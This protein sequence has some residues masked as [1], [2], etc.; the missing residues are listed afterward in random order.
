MKNLK[1]ILIILLFFGNNIYSQEKELNTSEVLIEKANYLFANCNYEEAI[2]FYKKID[3]LTA[4]TVSL[5][6][7]AIAI[8]MAAL[9]Y[10]KDSVF[11]YLSS[12][13]NASCNLSGYYF[14]DFRLDPYKKYPEWDV[15]FNRF[16]ECRYAH[17][18]KIFADY[19]MM[20]YLDQKFRD[21]NNCK[22]SKFSK[23]EKD[24]L[25]L[26]QREIDSLNATFIYDY[27]INNKGEIP[28]YQTD[29][30]ANTGFIMVL[31]HSPLYVLKAYKREI[32]R[33]YKNGQILGNDYA[34]FQDKLLVN[35]GKK[36]LYGTQYKYNRTT[37]RM[38]R[39]PIKRERNLN[40]RIKKFEVQN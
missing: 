11:Y 21:L 15:I 16:K 4:D 6:K 29:F 40:K 20:L 22:F 2:E 9:N 32:N 26:L 34:L 18:N 27:L 7:S 39:V 19:C 12:S 5:Y 31:L 24:S 13:I 10:H 1:I 30:C 28:P 17:K 14:L 23:E 33:A 37:Q 35:Q 3:A 8:S 25:N 36:Q 38:E